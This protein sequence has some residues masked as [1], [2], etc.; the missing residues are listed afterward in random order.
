MET[1]K[2]KIKDGRVPGV[3][4]PE[5]AKDLVVKGHLTYDQAKN[6]T[7]FGTIESVTYDIAEGAIVGAVAGG[8]SFALS[9][10]V[11]YASTG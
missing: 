7:K 3:S 10:C 9:A 8:I 2:S 5:Q 6:I 4:D 11:Y 1:M